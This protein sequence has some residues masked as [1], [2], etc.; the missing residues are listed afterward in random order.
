MALENE[1]IRA[2][3]AEETLQEAVVNL[4]LQ[5]MHSCITTKSDFAASIIHPSPIN[6]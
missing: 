1:T 4:V 3:A 6:Y 5:S 2:E